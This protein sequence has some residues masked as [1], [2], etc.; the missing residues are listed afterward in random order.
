MWTVV[1]K[2]SLPVLQGASCTTG[3]ISRGRAHGNVFN[4]GD[5]KDISE[6][7]MGPMI[8]KLKV[9]NIGEDPSSRK[10]QMTLKVKVSGNLA[11]VLGELAKCYS[12]VKSK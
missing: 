3:G 10:P 6:K 9:F 1:Q 5:S 2:D 8:G 7:D 12:P 11:P 4:I